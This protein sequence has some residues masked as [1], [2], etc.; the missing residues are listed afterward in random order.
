VTAKKDTRRTDYRDR[1]IA[2]GGVERRYLHDAETA[3]GIEAL[4][5]HYGESA[6]AVIARL[7]RRAVARL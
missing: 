6:R 7:V 1:V 5:A 4:Q 2:E 3:A